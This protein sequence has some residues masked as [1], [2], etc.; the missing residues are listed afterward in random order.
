MNEIDLDTLDAEIIDIS[1]NLSNNNQNNT[2]K[3]KLN[4]SQKSINFGPGI[5]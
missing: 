4:L 3:N 2:D 1:E 5:E